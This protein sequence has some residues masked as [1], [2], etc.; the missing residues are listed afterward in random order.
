[1]HTFLFFELRDTILEELLNLQDPLIFPT[2]VV[3]LVVLYFSHIDKTRVII[4]FPNFLNQ[5][6]KKKSEMLVAVKDETF[7]DIK[8]SKSFKF[9]FSIWFSL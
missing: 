8:E 3:S 5:K 6:E 9:I 2:F 1:M 7:L 4:L